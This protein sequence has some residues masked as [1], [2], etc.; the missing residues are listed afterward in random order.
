[1]LAISEARNQCLKSEVWSP[2]SEVWSL[3]S[4]VWSLKSEVWSPK[5]EVRSLKSEVWS[6]KSEVPSRLPCLKS[7]HGFRRFPL[8]YS[9]SKE[10]GGPGVLPPKMSTFLKL[11]AGLHFWRFLKQIRKRIGS[12]L[13]V[14]YKN[15]Y[16]LT[17]ITTLLRQF[18]LK[19]SKFK[20][21]W[22]V[23]PRYVPGQGHK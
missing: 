14:F 3:K 21:E 4:E 15:V 6:L 11:H 1:M 16:N 10:K 18:Y 17:K 8:S 22:W 19:I 5:S 23:T 9:V 2:K 12:K 20:L 7:L 13:I